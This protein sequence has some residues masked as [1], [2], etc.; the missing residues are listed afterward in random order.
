MDEVRRAEAEIVSG[1]WPGPLHGIPVAVND[2][3]NVEGAASGHSFR[4]AI[5]S[6]TPLVNC[7]M[8]A[9]AMLLGKPRKDSRY[10]VCLSRASRE[11]FRRIIPIGQQRSITGRQCGGLE[12]RRRVLMALNQQKTPVF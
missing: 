4:T 9:G 1:N 2:Q 7:R 5:A 8:R 3:L 10:R 11:E 6:P 12:T